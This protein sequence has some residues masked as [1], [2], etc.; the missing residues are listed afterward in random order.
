MYYESDALQPLG[1]CKALYPFDGKSLT[2][3][4]MELID[5]GLILSQL[6]VKAVFQWRKVKN[7][8]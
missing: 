2:S 6:Q 8:M 1:T 7:F 5:N 4:E 3:I